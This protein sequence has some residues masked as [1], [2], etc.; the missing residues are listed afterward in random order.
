MSKKIS[1]QWKKPWYK[2]LLCKHNFQYYKPKGG[3]RLASGEYRYLICSKC[4]KYKNEI[5][6]EYEGRGFK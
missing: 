6:L 5:F 1:I 4:G 3:S 2:R